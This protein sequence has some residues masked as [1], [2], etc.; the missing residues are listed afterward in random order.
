MSRM[1]RAC[2]FSFLGCKRTRCHSEHG[3]TA[4]GLSLGGSQCVRHL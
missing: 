4:P 1:N 2:R 3:F